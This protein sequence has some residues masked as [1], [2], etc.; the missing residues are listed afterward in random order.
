MTDRISSLKL[1]A[2]II[3]LGSIAAGS[4]AHGL[5]STTGSRRIQELEASLGAALIDRTTRSLSPTEAGRRL[6]AEI[7]DPLR[8]LSAALRAASE[9]HEE[10]SGVLRVRARRSFGM[11]HIAPLLPE[12]LKKYPRLAI[13]LELTERVDITPGDDADV[14]I[15]LGIPPEK[16]I[17][18]HNLA[19]GTRI[20]CASPGYLR[21]HQPPTCVNDLENHACLTYRREREPAMWVF[22]DHCRTGPAVR[23]EIKVTGPL[24]AT[25]G[26]MLRDAAIRG[27][28]LVLLPAWMV[29]AELR[30]GRL[31]QVLASVRAWPAGFSDEIV[32][33]YRRTKRVP[34]KIAAFVSAV[35]A[36][37]VEQSQTGAPETHLP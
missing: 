8:D 24:R 10:P 14:V 26:E 3:E 33:A 32:V 31:V 1:L 12:F 9:H 36:L 19:S 15:R 37:D 34:A 6:I 35:Q 22:E 30:A 28:G 11:M 25:N 7:K 29:S 4:R 18:I 5:S 20:L 27:L 13:D 17:T 16:S 21:E 2:S 23:R